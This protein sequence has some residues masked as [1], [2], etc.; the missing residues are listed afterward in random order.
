MA[1]SLKGLRNGLE[2]H[3]GGLSSLCED[4]ERRSAEASKEMIDFK[5]KVRTAVHLETRFV[6]CNPR[7][8]VY[9]YIFL[10]VGLCRVTFIDRRV[11]NLG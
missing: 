6:F 3:E 9:I 1:A 8:L 11:S 4:V 10:I 2:S 5:E 7:F